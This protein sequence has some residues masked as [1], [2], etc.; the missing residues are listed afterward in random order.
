[1]E[2]YTIQNWVRR[3]FISPPEHK[4]YSKRQFCRIALIN[5]LKD[6]MQMDSVTRLLT[7]ING[8]LSDESD[9]LIDDTLLYAM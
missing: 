9:D 1:L 2:A 6:C 7:Y 3:G 8:N 4:R 5:A